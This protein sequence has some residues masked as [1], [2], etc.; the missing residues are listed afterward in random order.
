[1]TR[2]IEGT[3]YTFVPYWWYQSLQDGPLFSSLVVASTVS[4]DFRDG[5]A[6]KIVAANTDFTWAALSPTTHGSTNTRTSSVRVNNRLRGDTGATAAVLAHEVYHA[7]YAQ[8]EGAVGCMQDEANA[9]SWG[10]GVWWR[11]PANL[12]L[13][14]MASEMNGLV[15]LTQRGGPGAVLQLVQGMASYRDQCSGR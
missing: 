9:F 3:S 1:V 14:S 6:S 4:Q 15:A 10:T 11:L 5:P 13:G 12:K 7:V 2:T 8:R